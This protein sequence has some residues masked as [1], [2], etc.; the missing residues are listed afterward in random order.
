[1]I[2]EKNDKES[3]KCKGLKHLNWKIYQTPHRYFHAIAQ[4][5]IKIVKRI[6][7]PLDEIDEIYFIL[8]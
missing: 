7:R 8:I 1:M 3:S 2:K 4:I 5:E 6:N